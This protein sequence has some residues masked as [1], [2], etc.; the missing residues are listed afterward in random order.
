MT[1]PREA[2]TVPR[3]DLPAWRTRLLELTSG[4]DPARFA[5]LFGSAAADGSVRLAAVLFP[6]QAEE[7]LILET[8]LPAADLSYETLSLRLPA[9]FWYERA[10]HDL[11]GVEPTDHPRLDPLLL[12]L[13][14]PAHTPLPGK[15]RRPEPLTPEESAI[16]RTVLGPGVFTIAHGPVRSGVLESVEY[17]VETP[18]EDIPRIQIRVFHKHRGVSKSFEQRPLEDAVLVAERVEGIASIAHALAF[19]HA[20]ERLAGIDVPWAARLVRSLH[21]E[22]ERIAHHLDVMVKLTEAAG[23][24]VATARFGLHK[25]RVLRLVGR[26]CGSRFGRGVVVPGGVHELPALGPREID[27]ELARLHRDITSDGRAA[28]ATP[29]FLDRLR[30]TGP[31][32]PLLARAHGALGP[33][34][35]ASGSAP[36]GRYERPYDAYPSLGLGPLPEDTS[37]DALARTQVRWAEIEQ[38]FRLLRQITEELRETPDTDALAVPAPGDLNGEAA[39]WAEAPQGEVLYLVRFENGR[40]ARCVPRSASFH[41][42]VLLHEVFAGDILTDFPFIEASFGL[43]IAGVAL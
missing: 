7:P 36:D 16:P 21:A 42:L 8:L 3:Q 13:T 35:K 5:G 43:S 15:A 33:V 26:L 4:T 30:T 27:R 34:G 39:G 18:G 24:A 1:G 28:M 9:A 14:D 40:V 2:F 31:L 23:L 38:S 41:N 17:L 32:D 11:F 6:S 29:S 22:L 10:L 12:P 20:V 37:G 25:E 19:C